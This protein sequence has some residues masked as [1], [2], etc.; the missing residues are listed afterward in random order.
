[1][2]GGHGVEL[3][4]VRRADG[5]VVACVVLQFGGDGEGGGFG[6]FGEGGGGEAGVDV[7][8]GQCD[9]L[10]G[11]AVAEDEFVAE[12]DFG[13]VKAAFDGEGGGAVQFGDVDDAVVV[14][15]G[16]DLHRGHGGRGYGV[17]AV[18]LHGVHALVGGFD[19]GVFVGG[20]FGAGHEGFEC[21]V[22]LDGG[23]VGLAVDGEGDHFASGECAGHLAGDGDVAREV[24]G[25]EEVVARQGVQDEGRLGG[26]AACFD[27]VVLRGD[28]H[29]ATGGDEAGFD[30]GVGVGFD[31]EHV[32]N[33]AVGAV[34]VDGGFVG[35]AVEGEFDFVACGVFAGDF[36][37][38][39]VVS[40]TGFAGEH[41]VVGAH[42]VDAERGVDA[43]GD[44]GAGPGVVGLGTVFV[45]VA[46]GVCKFVAGQADAGGAGGAG[47]GRSGEGGGVDQGVGRALLQWA[48]GA[49]CDGEVGVAQAGG[50]FRQCEGECGA[51][52]AGQGCGERVDGAG[53]GD[54]GGHGVDGEG[55]DGRAGGDAA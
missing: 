44:H 53:D 9:G 22:C 34:G 51:L 54:R 24:G 49:A 50:G 38:D 48:E 28:D 45:G 43:G 31:V 6:W 5:G 14:D 19:A 33:G 25:V 40:R 12:L 18:V 29:V 4:R 1:M 15:V 3:G 42:G 27:A 47:D 21:A 26:G 46:C 10:F 11:A 39:G 16:G 7:G 41:D 52:S 8:L 17:D 37:G 20:Q 32:D 35:V 13:L 55:G 36:A 23:G 2:G 30:F